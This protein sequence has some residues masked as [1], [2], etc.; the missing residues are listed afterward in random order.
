[1]N[2]DTII[3]WSKTE[4]LTEITDKRMYDFTAFIC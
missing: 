3:S 4:K 1:M 2:I